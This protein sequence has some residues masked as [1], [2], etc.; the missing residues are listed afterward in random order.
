MIIEGLCFEGAEG[1]DEKQTLMPGVPMSSL[2]LQ[3]GTLRGRRIFTT[4]VCFTARGGEIGDVR[5]TVGVLL[6]LPGELQHSWQYGA[7]AKH[8]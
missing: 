8:N 5:S 7:T 3:E 2:I 6:Y 1:W 4:A